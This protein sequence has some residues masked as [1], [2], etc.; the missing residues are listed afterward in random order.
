MA[1]RHSCA[2]SGGVSNFIQLLDTP[3]TYTGQAGKICVVNDSEDGIIFLDV[4]P[5]ENGGTGL[6]TYTTGDVIFSDGADSLDTLPIGTTGQ[7]L[8]VDAFSR[9]EKY[10]ACIKTGK[11]DNSV[12]FNA[13]L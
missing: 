12:P 5:P 11:V 1:T 13:N 9:S 4:L 7:V 8:T 2:G 6:D 10:F 3:A